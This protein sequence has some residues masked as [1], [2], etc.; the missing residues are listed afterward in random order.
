MN[1]YKTLSAAAAALVLSG[2]VALSTMGA[3][4]RYVNTPASNLMKSGGKQVAKGGARL[5]KAGYSSLVGSFRNSGSSESNS[6]ASVSQPL[7]RAEAS[8]PIA[9]DAEAN[10]AIG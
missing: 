5:A 9:V 4:N 3:F 2:G 10:G 1:T 8:E 7:Q 6:G